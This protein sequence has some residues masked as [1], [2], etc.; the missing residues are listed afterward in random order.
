MVATETPA[1]PVS[2]LRRVLL[3]L[4]LGTGLD[5]IAQHLGLARDEV[6]AMVEY[7]VRR[8]RL[9]LRRIDRTCPT[10]GCGACPA[11]R[12]NAAECSGSSHD[13]PALLAISPNRSG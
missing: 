4:Q 3:E 5:D 1:R 13:S 12:G 7:W 9:T 6:E 2:P 8:G 10:G 11:A